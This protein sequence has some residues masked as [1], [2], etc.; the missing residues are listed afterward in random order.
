MGLLTTADFNTIQQQ[1]NSIN[2]PPFIGRIPGKFESGVSGFTTDQLKAWTVIY[3]PLVLNG[4]LP[5]NHYKMWSEFSLAC[6]LLCKPFI[7]LAEV[8]EADEHLM[9]FCIQF[10]TIFGPE[11]VTPNM[12]LH[13]HL[14]KCVIDVGPVHSF[15]CFSFESM[16]ENMQ[17][18]WHSPEVQVMQKFVT[19][20]VLNVTEF[21]STV[22][23]DVV[24]WFVD[25]KS[26]HETLQFENAVPTIDGLSLLNYEKNLLCLPKNI[27]ALKKDFHV[28]VPPACTRKIF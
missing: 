26:H 14:K 1:V 12:H 18:N 6:A 15:W 7:T 5:D 16:L 17:K 19:L 11:K 2:V 21:P 28:I 20:Q 10:E 27:C 13:G 22:P 9:K 8:N 3:S 25:T 4:I 23:N 24:Q